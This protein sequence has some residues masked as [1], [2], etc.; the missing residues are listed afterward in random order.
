MKT[1]EERK[2]QQVRE[3]LGGLTHK[4]PFP[5]AWTR[6]REINWQEFVKG[7]MAFLQTNLGDPSGQIRNK[8]KGF[9]GYLWSEVPMGW[10]LSSSSALVMSIGN[11]VN[12]LFGLGLSDDEIVNLGYCEHYNG[13]K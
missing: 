2:K 12:T 3:G 1:I 6:F 9:N 10:G 8:L 4:D 11:L 5:E 7:I 13:T